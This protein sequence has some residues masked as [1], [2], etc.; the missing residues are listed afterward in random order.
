M[1]CHN[2]LARAYDFEMW[3]LVLRKLDEIGLKSIN[4]IINF[5]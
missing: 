4:L 5:C 2:V 1:D 3:E